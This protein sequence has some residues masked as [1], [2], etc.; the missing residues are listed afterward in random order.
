M[1]GTP[2]SI[3][4]SGTMTS[5]MVTG[6]NITMTTVIGAEGHGTTTCFIEVAHK[7]TTTEVMFITRLLN[8]LKLQCYNAESYYFYMFQQPSSTSLKKFN[9]FAGP[10]IPKGQRCFMFHYNMHGSD[11]G[12]LRFSGSTPEGQRRVFWAAQRSQTPAWVRHRILFNEDVQYQ[13][14][15]EGSAGLKIGVDH[16]QQFSVLAMDSF[17]MRNGSDLCMGYMDCNFESSNIYDC[18]WYQN[19]TDSADWSR[20]S[21]ETPAGNELTGPSSDHTTG[22]K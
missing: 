6:I 13:M 22:C 5:T 9:H 7:P 3:M 20:Q 16:G 10:A 12:E 21:G 18:G 11:I 8:D 15:F 14:L 2:C 19:D 1:R 4:N 17:W